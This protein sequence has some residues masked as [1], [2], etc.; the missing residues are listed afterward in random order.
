M[1]LKA[2]VAEIVPT[3]LVS[4]VVDQTRVVLPLELP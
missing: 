4:L 2:H 1:M 3:P